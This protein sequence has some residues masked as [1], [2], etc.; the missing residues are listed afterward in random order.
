MLS[1]NLSYN[2]LLT[3]QYANI[4][5]MCR[6]WIASLELYIQSTEYQLAMIWGNIG[7]YQRY[8]SHMHQY[9]KENLPNQLI[10]LWRSRVR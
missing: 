1:A 6:G 4:R 2:L 8:L 9:T 3:Y 5:Q 10:I 7:V